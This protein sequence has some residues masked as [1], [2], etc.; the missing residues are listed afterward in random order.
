LRFSVIRIDG[1]EYADAPHLLGL[2][3]A[4]CKRP[5]G[6][7]VSNEFVKSRRLIASP[8]AQNSA[9]MM[10]Y[11]RDLRSAK[12]GSMINLRC[13]NLETPMSAMGQKMG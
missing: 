2:L 8:E 1:H 4:R 12:W 11:I 3:R 6:Y 13:K 5:C 7:R 9:T 10:D